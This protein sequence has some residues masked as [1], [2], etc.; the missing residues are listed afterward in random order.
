LPAGEDN[1]DFKKPEKKKA[2]NT[3]RIWLWIAAGVIM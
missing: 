3:N 2:E 1:D